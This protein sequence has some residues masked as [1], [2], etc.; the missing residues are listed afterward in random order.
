MVS[1]PGDQDP[2]KK[3]GGSK[4][5]EKINPFF[6]MYNDMDMNKLGRCTLDLASSQGGTESAHG[7]LDVP[8]QAPLG[9]YPTTVPEGIS[10]GLGRE[11]ERSELVVVKEE[12]EDGEFESVLELR[13]SVRRE[14][15]RQRELRV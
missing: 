6:E 14:R 15:N 11:R 10:G 7:S 5:L 3:F 1:L 8:E 4:P 9:R 13:R 12:Q 2:I